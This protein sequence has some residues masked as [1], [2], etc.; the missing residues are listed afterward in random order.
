MIE[1]ADLRAAMRAAND[2]W[3]G[4]V[5]ELLAGLG[6]DPAACVAIAQASCRELEATRAPL[7][8]LLGMA[9]LTGMELGAR[10]VRRERGQ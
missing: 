6:L 8:S 10:A 3:N 1:L 5:G 2:E 7:R 4:D 9:F